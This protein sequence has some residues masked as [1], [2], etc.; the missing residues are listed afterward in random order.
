MPVVFKG[1][2]IELPELTVLDGMRLAKVVREAVRHI[3]IDVEEIKS[4]KLSL[5]DMFSLSLKIIDAAFDDYDLDNDR[6]GKFADLL[7]T[8][9][10]RLT[11]LPKDE[12]LA[13]GQND[14]VNLIT[15]IWQKEAEGPFVQKVWSTIRPVIIPLYMLFGMLKAQT[16][17]LL[18]SRGGLMNGGEYLSSSLL[19]NLA[20]DGESETSSTSVSDQPLATNEPV[21]SGV[22]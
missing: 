1:Q 22:S 15:A 14:F 18:L 21:L 7:F 5:A 6:L 20:T 11:K 19:S 8:E 17:N 16:S 2:E 13:A 9:L 10:S 3:P 4:M 12:I